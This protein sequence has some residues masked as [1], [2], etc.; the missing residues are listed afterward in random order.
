LLA[1]AL[2][3]AV[4]VTGALRGPRSLDAERTRLARTAIVNLGPEDRVRLDDWSEFF[5]CHGLV[6][7][8]NLMLATMR[9]NGGDFAPDRPIRLELAPSA[10]LP[11]PTAAEQAVI[12]AA[13]ALANAEPGR[14]DAACSAHAAAPAPAAEP[15]DAEALR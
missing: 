10:D 3:G 4:I 9:A 5:A 7:S 6:G 13:A 15:A 11:P 2:G 8:N 1:V 12:E 14:R